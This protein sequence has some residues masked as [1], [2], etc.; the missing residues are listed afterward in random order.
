MSFRVPSLDEA[1]RKQEKQSAEALKP[2]SS[3]DRR[4]P[5][6]AASA[7]SG[8]SSSSSLPSSSSSS[9]LAPS[10][11]KRPRNASS[12]SAVT[13]PYARHNPYL[14]RSRDGG[15]G[16]G[17]AN[18]GG[19]A[20]AAAPRPANPYGRGGGGRYGK[21]RPA[22]A[23]AGG[24]AP[25]RPSPPPNDPMLDVVDAGA[26]F[27]QA[28]GSVEDSSPYRRE[29]AAAVSRSLKPGGDE[30]ARKLRAEQRA[31][32][33]SLAAEVSGDGAGGASATSRS[34]GVDRP[35]DDRTILQPHVLHVSNRQRGNPLLRLIRN[36]P[37]AH[38]NIIPDYLLGTNRCALFLSVK[39]HNLHPNYVHRRISE[40]GKDFDLRVL[41]VKVDVE[42]N[43]ATLLYLNKLA[44]I[45]DLTLILAWSDDE[46]AR[47]LETYKA[48]EGKDA[49][50]IQ[51]REQTTYADRVSDVLCTV[52]SV[53]KT[54]AAQLVGQF[55]S[56]RA[57]V[58]ASADE[59]SL[60]P[61]IGAKKVR[62]LWEAFHRPFSTAAVRKK[63][64]LDREAEEKE[65]IEK[66]EDEYEDE[67]ESDQ[68]YRVEPDENGEAEEKDT[69]EKV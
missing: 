42:D 53:N 10:Q 3:L 14:K 24:A 12:G 20:G 22:C 68:E 29:A 48:F 25:P 5:T 4:R 17:S 28:F 27:S 56:L 36:V 47:Y 16:G 11:T 62:R 19:D 38:A 7:P 49:S 66:N 55:G 30:E 6:S 37:W 65:R 21:S 63:R 1:R 8:P 13:N 52:R 69:E 58:G 46:C 61:G 57:L 39:Y 44:V 35:K 33:S 59:L 43:A 2:R 15:G 50:S 41:L 51:K 67:D 26:T 60:C 34:D 32:D 9:S 23:S 40:L 64:R 54:D 31:F 45:N 18:G